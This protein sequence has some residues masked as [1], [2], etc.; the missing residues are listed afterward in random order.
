MGSKDR[1]LSNIEYLYD[2][3]RLRG[4]RNE[5]TKCI[6][7]THFTEARDEAVA[8]WVGRLPGNGKALAS[9]PRAT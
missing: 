9:V 1:S 6:W 5:T 8:Q 7:K 4:K 2:K 3:P